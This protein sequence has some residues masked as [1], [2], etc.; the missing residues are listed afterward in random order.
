M[1]PRTLV[2]QNQIRSTTSGIE[3]DDTLNLNFAESLV[4]EAFLDDP[5]QVS[6]TLVMDMNYLRTAMRDIK[7]ASPDFN[8]YDPVADTAGLITLSGARG[9]ITNV[10]TFVGSDNDFDTTPDYSS[11]IYITQNGSLE[12]A[13]G[14]LDAALLTISG[15]A[16]GEI[17]KRKLVLTAGNIDENTTIDLSSPVAGLDSYGDT[18]TWTSAFD[19]VENVSVFVNGVLQLPAS[20]SGDN[21]DVYHVA[22]PDQM[23]FE[24]K[25]RTNDVI[26]VW[27]FPPSA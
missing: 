7:G 16:A 9:A 4:N 24:F 15:A 2:V 5:T 1:S 19:F 26:Q 20:G 23:A 3:Y 27:K 13:I 18:I 14:E 11:T 17:A 25:L 8:W 22:T 6:G 21:N 12:Q 10:Q